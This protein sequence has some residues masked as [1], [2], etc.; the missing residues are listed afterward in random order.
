MPDQK[1]KVTKHAMRYVRASFH[2]GG[3]SLVEMVVVMAILV[4]L[5]GFAATHLSGG[6]E[7]ARRAATDQVIG[8]IEQA[9]NTA[10]V[11]RSTVMLAIAEPGSLPA[12]DDKCV[13]GLLRVEGDWD[14]MSL[15]PVSG[16]LLGRWKPLETGVI[17]MGGAMGSLTNPLDAPEVP[18]RYTTRRTIEAEVRGIIFNARGRLIHPVGP[19][20]AV[21]RIAEG[22]Y[23][24]GVPTPMRRGA[25]QRVSDTWLKIGRVTGRAYEV[26]P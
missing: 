19:A 14:P 17:F 11:S 1:Q 20:P 4:I 2:R 10:L 15:E 8:M 26:T 24:R 13:V 7:K 25:D 6:A 22:G 23:P 16:T 5:I 9:R 12:N 18:I 21:L 3:F